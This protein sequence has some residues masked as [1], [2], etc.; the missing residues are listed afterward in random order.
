MTE[1]KSDQHH[2]ARGPGR[3]AS[4]REQLLGQRGVTVW[5]TGPLGL[6]QVDDRGRRREGAARARP[7]RLRARRRQHPPRPEQEPRLLARRPHREHPPHRRGGEA[8][9]RRRR[10]RA[11]PRSSR[12]TAPTATRCARS[13]GRAT[14]SRC[15][16]D[17]ERRDLRGARREGPLQEG[18]RR[19]RSR[20]SPGISAPYEA[21][22]RARAGARHRE[23][24]T[25][26]GERGARSS[27]YLEGKGYLSA[28][29]DQ[30][31]RAAGAMREDDEPVEA[32]GRSRC[33]PRSRC[34]SRAAP[35]SGRARGAA[36]GARC[37]RR[38]AARARLP[39]RRSELELDG[40]LEEA[41]AAYERALA[42][43]PRV[44][45][46]L[47]QALA[48]LSR[49]ASRLE[50]RG[51]ARRARLRARARRS[52]A[53]RLFLGSSTASAA[54][55][56]RGAACCASADGKPVDHRRR[57]AALR[58]LARGRALR[59]GARRSPSWLIAAR[60]RRAARLDRA[61]QRARE[62]WATRR[63][64]RRRCARRC[65]SD[66]GEL[67]L[68]GALAREAPRARR[69]RRRDRRLSR[70]ARRRAR[71]PRDAA[72]ARRG[73]DRRRDVE[74]ERSRRSSGS[75]RPTP[76][77]CA[78]VLR[79]G[80]LELR[81]RRLR[82]RRAAASS[83][84]S[85]ASPSSTR[86]RS[87]SAWR[88]AGWSRPDE[89]IAPS[90]AIPPE[91]RALRRG[92]HADRRRSTSSTASIEPRAR[93]GRARARGRA[94]ARP[95]ELYAASLRSK[96]G[97]FDGR[98]RLPRGPAR[99]GARR[100]RAAL[101]HRRHLR[102]GEARRR[103]DPLHASSRS[104]KNPDN[105]GALNFIGYTW[106]ERGENLDEA[107][108]HHHARDRAAAR[109]RLHHR[110]PRLGLLHARAAAARGGQRRATREQLA[111]ARDR[112][113]RARGRAH[114]RRPGDLRAPRRR[115]SRARP[116]GA[117][118][119]QVRGGAAARAARE[120][121]AEAAREARTAAPRARASK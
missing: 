43:D 12:P 66:P 22:E 106:A 95:L 107:E 99:R 75:R 93:R 121:A 42:K 35:R 39:G 21:P 71:P 85:R 102:R 118:A 110:Q 105:A 17:G 38:R 28:Q 92:A 83:A 62:A 45:G 108:A 26:R 114:R 36:R 10:D 117:R 20:S 40:Q 119:R 54:S 72:R 61:R 25:G 31:A 57:A 44:A 87:S 60:A 64:P 11:A 59:R 7:A 96:S 89:A 52:Q 86:S 47:L 91:P 23:R 74:D 18:A 70:D 46:L 98:G 116:E 4:D 14:S 51:R 109:R 13:C 34:S 29:P 65:S 1:Q 15:Y 3:P 111:R 58:D 94:D 115:V 24:Q 8:L 73:A 53:L 27:R 80:F 79:L 97:D 103:G 84:R 19:A 82:G 41:L 32:T 33:S 30:P 5:L 100:R 101:Q 63:T 112:G 16:V 120:R 76:T 49:A 113:A 6:R 2:L 55:P 69:P 104:S 37:R 50:R 90:S 81:G 77:T 78:R 48:E 67:A 56:V 68:Y 88:C 9:H